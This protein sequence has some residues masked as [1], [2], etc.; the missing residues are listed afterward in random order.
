M[1]LSNSMISSLFVYRWY[2]IPCITIH[3]DIHYDTERTSYVMV[4]FILHLMFSSKP[5]LSKNFI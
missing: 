5:Y 3:F 1:N 2:Y 4:V